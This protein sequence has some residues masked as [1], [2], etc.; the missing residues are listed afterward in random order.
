[1]LP[2]PTTI[3][4]EMTS[5]PSAARPSRNPN[6][7]HPIVWSMPFPKDIVD[8]LV[9]WTT[10]QGTVNNSKLGL[11]GG[12]VHSDCVAQFFVVK[13][14]T[15]LSRT[16]N[17]EGLWW[18]CKVSATC[19]SAPEHLLQFQAMHQRFHHF[20]CIDFVSGVESI[21]SDRPSRSSDRTDNQLFAYLET[22]FPQPLPWQLWTLSPKLA[23]GIASALQ[24]MTSERGCLL[25]EPLTPMATGPSGPTSAQGWP[26]TPY[27]LLTN[28]LSPSSTTLLGTTEFPNIRGVR[29]ITV[30][31][32]VRSIGQA[33]AM[34]GAKDP[35]MTSTGKID[36]RLQLQFRCYSQQDTPPSRVKPIPVQ[37]LRRL[38]CVAAASNDQ[39]LQAVADMIIIA[40]FFLLRP[41]EYTVTKP[42]STPFRLS[43]VTFSVGCM[44][45]DTN[46]ATD[47]E[48]AAAT[49]VILIF[50]TQKNGVRGGNR[51]W[52]HRRPAVMPEGGLAAL[53][54]A[55]PTT[56]RSREHP[57]CPFQR[58]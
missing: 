31:D 30:E 19:T 21:I 37:V 51:P 23:S 50:S 4:Q 12:V 16:D 47:N 48:L 36:G 42:D 5:Q 43:D 7:A 39:E 11:A 40:F 24:R 1:M 49:F 33:I 34:L 18:Q 26:S 45:F 28:T 35:R 32:A 6:G 2:G 52:G 27:L 58:T 38:A 13:G 17:T 56:G 54:D 57:S 8:S 41:G 14:R 46:T 20:S 10:P 9:S 55:P 53:R 3:P 22:N 25:A 44:E 15:T 29:S